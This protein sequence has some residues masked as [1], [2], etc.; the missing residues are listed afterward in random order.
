M[1]SDR[2]LPLPTP[3]QK[4]VSRSTHVTDPAWFLKSQP[5]RCEPGK[6]PLRG[7]PCNTIK[8]PP[9][10]TDTLGNKTG[11]FPTQARKFLLS[12]C[13]T[14]QQTQTFLGRSRVSGA[15]SPG[16]GLP[17]RLVCPHSALGFCS[18]QDPQ[19]CL[20]DA[21]KC[22]WLHLKLV[23]AYTCILHSTHL[24]IRTFRPP[25]WEARQG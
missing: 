21:N 7:Q 10:Q 14:A 4:P 23:F 6:F 15:L 18:C 3:A 12:V 25:L 8:S 19:A 2:V 13:S 5:L 17:K 22:R 11:L 24:H 1:P 9:P 16:R 20:A